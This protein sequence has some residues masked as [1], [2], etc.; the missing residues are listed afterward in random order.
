MLGLLEPPLLW[1]FPC[2]QGIT[3]FPSTPK[4]YYSIF[5]SKLRM[6]CTLIFP[7]KKVA[8][9]MPHVAK[10]CHPQN[11]FWWLLGPLEECFGWKREM[12]FLDLVAALLNIHRYPRFLQVWSIPQCWF[13]KRLSCHLQ[14][15]CGKSLVPLGMQPH[16]SKVQTPWISLLVLIVLLH[17][18][19]TRKEKEG[20]PNANP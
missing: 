16:R 1:G 7:P 17:K 13:Y 12:F 10:W 15:K 18:R 14:R 5:L 2:L 3:I 4:A 6:C 19:E 11:G 8:P 20:H 9:N